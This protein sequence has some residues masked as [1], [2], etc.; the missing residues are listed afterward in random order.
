MDSKDNKEDKTREEADMT[1]S[2][3]FSY[4][5]NS[6]NS[7]PPVSMLLLLIMPLL[8]LAHE[9]IPHTEYI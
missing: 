3:F 7:K 4:L 5:C 1:L 6:A 2:P 8:M 9:S